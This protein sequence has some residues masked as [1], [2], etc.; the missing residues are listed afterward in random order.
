MLNNYLQKN[1]ISVVFVFCYRT[2]SVAAAARV[3]VSSC[4]DCLL[5][6]CV[7]VIKDCHTASWDAMIWLV[8]IT[9]RGVWCLTMSNM[10]GTDMIGRYHVTWHLMLDHVQHGHSDMIGRYHV[11]RRLMLDHVQHGRHR[12]DWSISRDVASDAWPCP[13]WSAQ[14]WLV[15]ITWRGVW[16]LTMSNMVGTDMIGRYHVMRRLMLDH[17]QHGRHRYDWS[18]SRDEASDAWPCP[19]WSA[20]IWLVDITWCGIWCL[21]MSNMVMVKPNMVGCRNCWLVESLM[22]SN[23]LSTDYL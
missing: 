14:I 23:L 18:I 13:T 7:A 21:T 8:D 2:M 11:T 12:Y 16:C 6:E 10:V 19:T 17:V 22:I 15:H 3:Q 1:N 9:W 20:Q 4:C 5:C